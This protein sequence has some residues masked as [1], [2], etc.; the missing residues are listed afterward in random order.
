MITIRAVEAFS[1]LAFMSRPRR[2]CKTPT[3]TK[4]LLSSDHRPPLNSITKRYL[5][6]RS[7][8]FFGKDHILDAIPLYIEPNDLVLGISQNSNVVDIHHS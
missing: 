8:L 6:S 2:V 7:S 3:T 1:S 4:Q 5:N